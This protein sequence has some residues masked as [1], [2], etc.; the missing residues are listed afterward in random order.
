VVKI[1]SDAD[2]VRGEV[3]LAGFVTRHHL[4]LA[5]QDWRILS[6]LFSW[7]G[8]EGA[9]LVYMLHRKSGPMWG[10]ATLLIEGIS[11]VSVSEWMVR[12]RASGQ[13]TTARLEH[14]LTAIETPG[15][16]LQSWAVR[17]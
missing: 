3:E 14:L 2:T 11:A 12:A 15:G 6:E 1:E 5:F 8:T 9:T 4:S 17:P 7:L 16:P 13:V 10:E